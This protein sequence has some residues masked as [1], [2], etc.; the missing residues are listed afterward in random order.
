MK[1]EILRGKK[2]CGYDANKKGKKNRVLK[3][4]SNA[5]I[6]LVFQ[7]FS[8]SVS[9]HASRFTDVKKEIRKKKK[10]GVEKESVY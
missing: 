10:Q 8:S 1:K 3:R 6:L 9:V 4:L 7:P 2:S 5:G